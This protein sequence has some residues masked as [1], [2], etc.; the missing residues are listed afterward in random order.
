VASTFFGKTADETLRIRLQ[1]RTF[2]A[3]REGPP[4][5]LC[6]FL[7]RSRFGH[8]VV[9]GAMTEWAA[10]SPLTFKPY[11]GSGDYLLWQATDPP[12]DGGQ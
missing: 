6:V 8:T 3:P 4:R 7:R 11:T 5:S 12:G 2:G 9:N 1:G 10:V